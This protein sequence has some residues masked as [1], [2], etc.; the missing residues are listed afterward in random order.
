MTTMILSLWRPRI[1]P[2]GAIL[3][4][5]MG[6]TPAMSRAQGGDQRTSVIT[7]VV[8]DVAGL[9]IMDVRVSVDTDMR[10]V[11]TD[12]DGR[13]VLDVAPGTHGFEARKVGFRSAVARVTVAA[14]SAIIVNITLAEDAQALP[15]VV[16]EAK[17]RNQ[18]GGV[19]VDKDDQAVADAVVE[20]I[21]LNKRLSTDAEGRFL[22]VD[23]DPGVYIL[24]IRK[25]GFRVAQA[26]LHIVDRLQRDMAVRLQPIGKSRYTA[27]VAAIAAKEGNSR[28]GLQSFKGAVVGREELAK[29]GKSRLD[30]ALAMSSASVAYAETAKSCALIDGVVPSSTGAVSRDGS[31]GL[32]RT[33]R[34]SRGP[35]AIGPPST[36]APIRDPETLPSWVHHFRADEVEMVE[37]YPQDADPSRTLCGRFTTSSG[38]SCPPEASGLVIWLR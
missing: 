4:I 25:S 8:R 31:G 33:V 2:L 14:D 16:V 6:S 32:S 35:V 38:C 5:L 3:L 36:K 19:V 18:V 12:R 30:Y 27:E 24:Q 11:L 15:R 28:I 29:F 26:G 7:G 1:V 37:L 34:G 13:F 21:G 22:F 9:P 23:L 20:V 17:I 10:A